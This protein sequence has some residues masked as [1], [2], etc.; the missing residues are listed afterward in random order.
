MKLKEI[1]LDNFSY[2]W[3]EYKDIIFV[4]S[5]FLA[6]IALVVGFSTGYNKYQCSKFSKLTG[7]NTAPIIFSCFV[8]VK[9]GRWVSLNDAGNYYYIDI[10][11]GE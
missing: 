2:F 3:D 1:L 6:I 7:L 9:E 11:S 10:T 8:E 4:V 5:L